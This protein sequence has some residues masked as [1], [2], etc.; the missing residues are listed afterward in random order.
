MNLLIRFLM[1]ASHAERPTPM[2][3][4]QRIDQ[5]KLG[6]RRFFSSVSGRVLLLTLRL[7]D[8]NDRA[9][10][11]AQGAVIPTISPKFALGVEETKETNRYRGAKPVP[12]PLAD[13]VADASASPAYRSTFA[14]QNCWKN[15]AMAPAAKLGMA[16]GSPGLTHQTTG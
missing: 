7:F 15:L 12:E 3:R 16:C 5:A 1:C 6:A 2:Q 11:W 14:G 4:R 8:R 10:A 9:L 13:L